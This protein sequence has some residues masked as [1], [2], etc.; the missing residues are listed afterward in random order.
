MSL[1][2]AVTIAGRE[3]RVGATYARAAEASGFVWLGD[4]ARLTRFRPAGWH[5]ELRVLENLVEV[6]GGPLLVAEEFARWAGPEI[7]APGEGR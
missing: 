1:I 5:G 3:F 7:A 4:S 2:D 6:N